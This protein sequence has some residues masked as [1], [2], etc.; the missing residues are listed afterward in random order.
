VYGTGLLALLS[1][2]LI[3]KRILDNP[4]HNLTAE[5]VYKIYIILSNFLTKNTLAGALISTANKELLEIALDFRNRF[6]RDEPISVLLRREEFLSLDKSRH[7]TFHRACPAW[8][9]K[10][11]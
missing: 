9:G 3:I 7:S 10:F 1:R 8:S 4:F 2:V 5:F 6:I 11:V